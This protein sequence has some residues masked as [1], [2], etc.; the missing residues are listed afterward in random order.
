MA[1]HAFGGTVARAGFAILACIWVY[2]GVRAWLAVRAREIAS[3]RRWMIRSFALTLAAVALRVYLP[4]ALAAGIEFETAYPIIA[5]LCWVPN[6]LV[7]E[8][9]IGRSLASPRERVT[10]GGSR[11]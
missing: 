4:S 2:T 9:L 1:F 7:A 5:W 10:D 11:G 8:F 6:L 3:H